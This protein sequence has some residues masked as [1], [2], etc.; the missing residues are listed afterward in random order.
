MTF[1]SKEPSPE[2]YTPP[3]IVAAV[4]DALGTIDLD[5]CTTQLVNN[6]FIRA[7]R[8]YTEKDNGLDEERNPW[9]GKIYVNPPGNICSNPG[10][11]NDM[12]Q[13]FWRRTIQEYQ[14]KQVSAA[15]FMS[16][17]I[18]FLQRSQNWSYPM[19]KYP[20]CIPQKQLT[21]YLEKGGVLKPGD[22]PAFA[23]AIIYIGNNVGRFTKAFANIGMVVIPRNQNR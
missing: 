18:E 22:Y 17:N 6:T 20:F 14:A 10:G 5:P 21:F 2:R 12:P 4:K 15:I 8:F 13:M 9:Q 19:L 11:A 16:Y 7:K 1:C 3:E 23:N